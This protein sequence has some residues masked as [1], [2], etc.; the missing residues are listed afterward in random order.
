[1]A[2]SEGLGEEW[3]QDAA[4]A[5]AASKATTAAAAAGCVNLQ[6]CSNNCIVKT[7]QS[8]PRVLLSVLKNLKQDICWPLLKLHRVDKPLPL[9][10]HQMGPVNLLP[11]PPRPRSGQLT[12]FCDI[13]TSTSN[14]QRN[15]SPASGTRPSTARH[16]HFSSL[17]EVPCPAAT[18]PVVSQGG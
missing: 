7:Q 15:T 8:L 11:P 13:P 4:A 12:T 9:K 6:H 5:A 18:V 17:Q 10:L 3:Q 16:T 1:M 2:T 14:Q